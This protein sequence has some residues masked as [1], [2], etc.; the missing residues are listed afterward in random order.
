MDILL[1][2]VGGQGILFITRIL[3]TSAI[4]RGWPVMASETHGMAQRGGTVLSHVRIGRNGIGPLIPR[5]KADL[6]I[7]LDED[8]G[9]RHL[10]YLCEGGRLVVNDEKGKTRLKAVTDYLSC[11]GIQWKGV[12]A[13]E[14]ARELNYPLGANLIL[15]GVASGLGW[16]PFSLGELKQSVSVLSR[17]SV[18]ERNTESLDAGFRMATLG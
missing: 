16:L 7:G 10:D 3:A 11:A 6:L 12:R 13:K 2:G 5:G 14:I 18:M 17:P 15:V 1:A 8:E 4:T 9:L